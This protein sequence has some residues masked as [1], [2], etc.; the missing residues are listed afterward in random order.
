[1]WEKLFGMHTADQELIPDYIT[2]STNQK[3]KTNNLTG[4]CTNKRNIQFTG[5]QNQGAQRYENA[6]FATNKGNVN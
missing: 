1:M 2:I 4:K 5:E 3:K 6:P